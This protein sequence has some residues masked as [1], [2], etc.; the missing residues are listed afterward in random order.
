ME[1]VE[2]QPVSPDVD[3]GASDDAIP[4]HDRATTDGIDPSEGFDAF[5]RATYASVARAIM[6]I[7]RD[8]A[9]GEELTQEAFARVLRRSERF[10]SED[11]RLRFTIKVAVN[12]ARSHERRRRIAFA[13]LGERRGA[14][15][16]RVGSHD[17]A[18][19][20]RLTLREALAGLSVRQRSCVALV[21]YLGVDPAH[22]AAILRMRHS[23]LRVH[24]TRGRRALADRLRETY[25]EGDEP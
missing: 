25:R 16:D 2:P 5:F 9:V 14:D 6:V 3:P 13:S 15:A 7:V 4:I 1:G 12:L 24:L 10:N 18:V 19:E 20:D 22:A 23:T 21:D 8:R 17:R 11:H